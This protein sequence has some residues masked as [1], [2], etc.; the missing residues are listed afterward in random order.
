M[1]LNA[2]LDLVALAAAL[3]AAWFW[4][5]ASGNTVRRI[6]KCEELNHLDINR[7]VVAVN[8]SQLLNRRAALATAIS[9]LAIA[10]KFAHDLAVGG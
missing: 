10:A 7:I 9:A 4:W 3:M 5:K 8:R 2:L 6:D 1:S